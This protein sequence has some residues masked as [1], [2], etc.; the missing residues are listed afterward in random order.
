MVKAQLVLALTVL[1]LLVPRT[2]QESRDCSSAGGEGA[3]RTKKQLLVILEVGGDKN[4][5]AAFIFPIISHHKEEGL[6]N[7]SLL[8][9]KCLKG[10]IQCYK[11]GAR[12]DRISC[13]QINSLDTNPRGVKYLALRCL[14]LNEVYPTQLD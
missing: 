4:D 12:L 11:T 2:L 8:L 1:F 10:M 6:N 3:R 9:D 14:E 13:P 7:S 5:C